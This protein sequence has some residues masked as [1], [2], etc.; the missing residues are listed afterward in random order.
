MTIK[1]MKETLKEMKSI[2]D[3]KDSETKISVRSDC[4]DPVINSN[5]V[6][7]TTTINGIF[8]RMD[9]FLEGKL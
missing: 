1:E 9:K 5:S 7:I 8:V 6:H 4:V 3:Y 2:C